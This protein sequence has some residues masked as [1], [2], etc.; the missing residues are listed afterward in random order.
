MSLLR[1]QCVIT[2][3]LKRSYGEVA[4]NIDSRLIVDFR[5]F[6]RTRPIRENLVYYSATYVDKYGMPQPTFDYSI[7]PPKSA[8]EIAANTADIDSS[9]E[10]HEMMAY[11]P[12]SAFIHMYPKSTLKRHGQRSLKN[13]RIVSRYFDNRV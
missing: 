8:Q 9:L 11:V 12:L 13:R 2:P 3:Y 5:W 4:E 1:L 10:A 6:G 7:P